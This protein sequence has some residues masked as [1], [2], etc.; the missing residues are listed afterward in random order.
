MSRI[1]SLLEFLAEEPDD[2]F[3]RYAL[4]MEY[5]SAGRLEEAAAEFGELLRRAPDYLP[6]Y[7]QAGQTL[8][9]LELADQAAQVLRRGMEL[10]AQ[11]N[12]AHTGQSLSRLLREVT[13]A[14]PPCTRAD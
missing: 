2:A 4:A 13:C 12:E 6:A 8:A 1:D 5:R 3:S 14:R 11:K 10:A 9:D 7:L